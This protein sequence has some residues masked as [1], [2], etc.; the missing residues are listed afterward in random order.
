MKLRDETA[1]RVVGDGAA[2][3]PPPAAAAATAGPGK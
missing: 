3:T 2:G 1:V